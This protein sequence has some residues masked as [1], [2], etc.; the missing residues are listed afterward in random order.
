MQIVEL[1]QI[2]RDVFLQ[3]YTACFHIDFDAAREPYPLN[4]EEKRALIDF[5]ELRDYEGEQKLRRMKEKAATWK[6]EE[7]ARYAYELYANS[8][9]DLELAFA[10]KEY[11]ML[12]PEA[13]LRGLLELAEAEYQE[14]QA[15]VAGCS[16]EQLIEL[17]NV[18]GKTKDFT[19]EEW[20]QLANAQKKK[21]PLATLVMEQEA[22][23]DFA[24][25]TQAAEADY[26]KGYLVYREGV[27]RSAA[28]QAE[29]QSDA[30][31]L[32]VYETLHGRLSQEEKDEDRNAEVDPALPLQREVYIDLMQHELQEEERILATLA[33]QYREHTEAYFAAVGR[34]AKEKERV[35]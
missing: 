10:A 8:C 6:K 35:A 30:Y 1:H 29:Q 26:G 17:W 24:V 9:N 21:M 20:R 27:Q 28:E 3:M 34:Y 14:E 4:V 22:E 31:Y 7:R 32:K 25:S 16:L 18:F 13:Y 33:Q 15:R 19:T 12:V 5:E 11:G 2:A 23:Q